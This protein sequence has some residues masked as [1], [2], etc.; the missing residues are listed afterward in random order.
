M[1]PEL[2]HI[3][4]A[5][6]LA[7]RIPPA[8]MRAAMAEVFVD[9]A[10]GQCMFLPKTQLEIATGHSFQSMMAVSYRWSAA[11]LKWVSVVP[12]TPQASLAHISAV[13][14]LND[15]ATG[16]PLALMDG[17]VITLLRTAAMSALA[18][19]RMFAGKPEVLAFAG[20]GGQARHHLDAFCDLFPSISRVLCF[21]RS[22][23]SAVALAA[24]ARDRGLSSDIVTDP[25][26]LLGGAD[27]VIS[28]IPAAPGLQPV[29]DVSAM[30]PGALAVMVDLGRSWKLDG[31]RGFTRIVTDSLEQMRHPVDAAGQPVTTAAIT[32]DLLSDLSPASD[33]QAFCFKGHAAGDLAAAVLVHDLV[34]EQGMGRKL[35]R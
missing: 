10:T 17:E 6:L 15:L 29:L 28:T 35:E 8:R 27:I 34:R 24:L 5:D 4:R 1:L 33:L 14:C 30:R 32:Q 19:Q 2:L 12:P 22:P 23:A 25:G 16:F 13:I 7:L 26:M 31:P 3:S 9:M 21:N 20:C 18:A 11:A